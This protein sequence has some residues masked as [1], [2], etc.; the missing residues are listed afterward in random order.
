M[1][2]NKKTWPFYTRRSQCIVTVMDDSLLLIQLNQISVFAFQLVHGQ[3]STNQQLHQQP[4]LSMSKY[5][6]HIR[7]IA[8]YRSHVHSSTK[9]CPVGLGVRYMDKFK[10]LKIVSHIPLHQPLKF[11]MQNIQII[12]PSK[13]RLHDLLQ[14]NPHYQIFTVV[15]LRVFQNV[16]FSLKMTGMFAQK[17]LRISEK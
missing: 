7:C 13:F 4:N 5:Q 9:C 16:V 10:V 2:N 11:Q 6:V 12:C 3:C 14:L 17:K 8:D 1:Y 15:Q